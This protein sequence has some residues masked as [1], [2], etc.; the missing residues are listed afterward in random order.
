MAG[1]LILVQIFWLM[2]SL[3]TI[4]SMRC[5]HTSALI[6]IECTFNLDQIELAVSTWNVHWSEMVSICI[7]QDT[8]VYR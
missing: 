7:S 2:C 1:L 6:R 8:Y 4:N 3:L 5:V